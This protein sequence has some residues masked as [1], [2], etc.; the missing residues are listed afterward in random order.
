MKPATRKKLKRALLHLDLVIAYAHDIRCHADLGKRIVTARDE[1]K[2]AL[3]LE[4]QLE[5]ADSVKR[6]RKTTRK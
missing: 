5:A 1:L 2:A 3:L 4:S 6:T